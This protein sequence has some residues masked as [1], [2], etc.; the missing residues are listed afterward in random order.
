MDAGPEG[1]AAVMATLRLSALRQLPWYQG[2]N[3]QGKDMAHM[4]EVVAGRVA[5]YSATSEAGVFLCTIHR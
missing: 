1:A 2:G 5:Y 3:Y 4:Q